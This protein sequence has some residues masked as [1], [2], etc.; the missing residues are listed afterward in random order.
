MDEN[1]LPENNDLD[2]QKNLDKSENAV[3]QAQPDSIETESTQNHKFAFWGQGAQLFIISIINVLLTIVT[4]GIYYPWAKA[5]KLKY[6][7]ENTEFAGS[8]FA[9]HGTGKEMFKGFIK[10]LIAYW[11][12]F[13][14]YLFLISQQ[15]IGWA[16][17][18]LLLATMFIY[19]L[20]IHGSLRY[21]LAR[22]S[23]R[24]IFMGYR[25]Q[26]GELI[27]IWLKGMGL[28]IITLGIYSFWLRA[29]MQTYILD[30]I[31]IGNNELEYKGKGSD[32][33]I[34]ALLHGAIIFGVIIVLGIA[35]ASFLGG[36]GAITTLGPHTFLLLAIIYIVYIF[37]FVIVGGLKTLADL[38]YN[39]ENTY[40]WQNQ[41]TFSFGLHTNIKDNIIMILKNLAL[42]IFTL[43]IGISWAK[44][45]V[46][47]YLYRRAEVD[48]TFKLS[49]LYQTEEDY[50]NATGDSMADFLNVDIV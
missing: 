10:V 5:T 32:L 22:T 40:L 3:P 36:L 39:A 1:Q 30:K 24:G 6:M 16:L 9:F 15:L 21:R 20:A 48:A 44:V 35:F 14:A 18:L 4:L 13:G 26:L 7:Y 29:N 2:Q 23:W 41:K 43:G 46:L 11:V 12:F 50:K 47:K 33:F 34:I 37:L 49:E 28:T 25:G 45:N 17:L 38:K 27:T 8:R 31:R 19:P 42:V